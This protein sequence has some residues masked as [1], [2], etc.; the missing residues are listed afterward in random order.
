M[1]SL[2]KLLG[3]LSASHFF[4]VPLYRISSYNYG[5]EDYDKK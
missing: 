3:K 2:L 5:E 1:Y 4:L